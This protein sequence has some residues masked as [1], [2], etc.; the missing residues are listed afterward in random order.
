MTRGVNRS[1]TGQDWT[2][3]RL[4]GGVWTEDRTGLRRVQDQTRPGKPETELVLGREKVEKWHEIPVPP[5]FVGHGLTVLR[6][7]PVPLLFC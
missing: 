7:T 3:D 4:R 6:G 5:L 2:E 1:R